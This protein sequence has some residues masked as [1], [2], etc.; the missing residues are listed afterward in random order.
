MKGAV[1]GMNKQVSKMD[2]GI[3]NIEEEV[4]RMKADIAKINMNVD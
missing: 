1:I 3:L 4:Y 2:E